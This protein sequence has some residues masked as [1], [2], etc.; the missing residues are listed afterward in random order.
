MPSL[1]DL[2]HH[3]NGK[4]CDKWEVYINIYENVLTNKKHTLNNLF[5]IGVQNGGSLEI[6][7]KYFKNANNIVGC[8]INKDC[9]KLK[10]NDPKIHLIVGDANDESIH[11]QITSISPKYDVIID[12]GSHTSSDIITSFCMYFPMLETD[13][14]YIIEDLHC[15]Y[16]TE[17]EG[18]LYAPTSSINFLKKLADIIN[19]QNWGTV[20]TISS[21]LLPFIKDETKVIIEQLEVSLPLIHS[22]TF[23]NSLCIIQKKSTE[24]NLLQKRVVVGTEADVVKDMLHLEDTQYINHVILDQTNNTL[25]TLT[26]AP[27]FDWLNQ[28]KIIQDLETKSTQQQAMLEKKDAEIDILNHQLAYVSHDF[29]SFRQ[30]TLIKLGAKLE[31]L[32]QKWFKRKR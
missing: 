4:V 13:G 23:Y 3:H 7:T 6:W 19:F 8:D 5:E 29:Y 20:Q 14:I 21:V 11:Q 22:I 15:S 31:R 12:D 26:L 27:E 16:W 1:Y 2:Y 24:N 10:F 18:G 32:R 28:K 25:A 17:F 9:H 30:I